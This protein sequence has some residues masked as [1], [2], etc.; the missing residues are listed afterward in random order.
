MASSEGGSS[1]DK[2]NS[3]CFLWPQELNCLGW[4]K[5]NPQ[6]AARE[7]ASTT[8]AAVH[9]I[10][11]TLKAPANTEA[12]HNNLG[13]TLRWDAQE[14]ERA[15]SQAAVKWQ[16]AADR[17]RQLAKVE[18]EQ[19]DAQAAVSQQQAGDNPQSRPSAISRL[20]APGMEKSD[21]NTVNLDGAAEARVLAQ[22]SKTRLRG[23][24]GGVIRAGTLWE[25][26]PALLLLLR[27]PG[28]SECPLT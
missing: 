20:G 5:G 13:G 12:V 3:H 6:E 16:S 1:R 22:I 25:E 11:V 9:V 17:I 10:K 14:A 8:D 18:R 26:T 4:S 15:S 28:C 23:T 19:I 27:R 21:R 2:P 7:V 24:D